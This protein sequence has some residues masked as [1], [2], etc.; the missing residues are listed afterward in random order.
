[1]FWLKVGE[2]FTLVLYSNGEGVAIIFHDFCCKKNLLHKSMSRH[3]MQQELLSGVL[4][5]PIISLSGHCHSYSR[6]GLSLIPEFPSK[7]GGCPFISC[8]QFGRVFPFFPKLTPLLRKGDS[9]FSD[10][11]PSEVLVLKNPWQEVLL[12]SGSVRSC[13][14]R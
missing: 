5:Y 14:L 13:T 10:S 2:V 3:M 6:T 1:M 4:V 8:N 12:L 11:S 7:G 9:V